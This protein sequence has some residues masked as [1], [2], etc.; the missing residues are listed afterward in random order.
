VG[1]DFQ[2]FSSMNCKAI[3]LKVRGEKDYFATVLW[4]GLFTS[5]KTT[6]L[7]QTMIRRF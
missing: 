6:R 3:G 4:K 1:L 5:E 2:N 7:R